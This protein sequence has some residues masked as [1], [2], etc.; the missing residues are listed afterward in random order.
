[1]S[2]HVNHRR[3]RH[4]ACWCAPLLVFLQLAEGGGESGLANDAYVEYLCMLGTKLCR[5][6]ARPWF[7]K[8]WYMYHYWYVVVRKS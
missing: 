8:L 3:F 7:I 4:R 2:E 5:I 1:M 6:P